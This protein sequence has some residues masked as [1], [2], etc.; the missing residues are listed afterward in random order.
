[1]P[2]KKKGEDGSPGSPIKTHKTSD[3]KEVREAQLK[4]IRSDSASNKEI[5][6][7]SK[8]LARMHHSLQAD[9]VTAKAVASQ[10]QVQAA[11]ELTK[12]EKELL[13]KQLNE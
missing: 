8:L 12:E 1:M 6:E 10:K 13:D 2:T 5:T 4:I 11:Q 7:A 3:I 9:K